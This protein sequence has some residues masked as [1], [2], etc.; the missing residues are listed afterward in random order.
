MH[1]ER[2][3]DVPRVVPITLTLLSPL[4]PSPVGN[5]KREIRNARRDLNNIESRRGRGGGGGGGEERSLKEIDSP[6]RCRK[7]VVSRSGNVTQE[8]SADR[9]DVGV[10]QAEVQY[11]NADNPKVDVHRL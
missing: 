5:Y 1:V 6:G 11:L 3:R 9:K 4:F 10:S 7:E 8:E 2:E